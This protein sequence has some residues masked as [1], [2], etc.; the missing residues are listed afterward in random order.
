M[1]DGTYEV[2]L[3]KLFL[4][5]GEDFGATPEDVLT[6]ILTHS[7]LIDQDD[8]SVLLPGVKIVYKDYDWESNA[9]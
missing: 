9:E 7:R 8:Q 2:S 1:H 3:S 4:W 5:Y 6:W